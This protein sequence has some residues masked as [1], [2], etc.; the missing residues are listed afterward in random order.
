MQDTTS[1]FA[2]IRRLRSQKL[3]LEQYHLLRHIGN[4]AAGCSLSELSA[5]RD[6]TDASTSA[7][8]SKFRAQGLIMLSIDP[9]D[10]RIRRIHLSARGYDLL[11]DTAANL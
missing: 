8:V 11:R 6:T 1:I 4:T 5:L 7:I 9:Q 10:H 3:T 2:I